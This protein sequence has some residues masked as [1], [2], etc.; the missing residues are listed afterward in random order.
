M[1]NRVILVVDDT[2]IVREGTLLVLRHMYNYETDEAADGLIAIEKIKIKTFDAILMD[3]DMPEMNGFE[4]TTQIRELE[5]L[6]ANRTIII[7]L[8]ASSVRDIREKCLK[9]G[10]DDYI[11]KSCSNEELNEILIKWLR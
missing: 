5:K 7:G 4:C 8:T 1:D 10:M 9:A 6:T 3:C 11:D 2:N